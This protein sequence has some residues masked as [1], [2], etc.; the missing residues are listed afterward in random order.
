MTSAE[1]KLRE[2]VAKVLLL[3]ESEVNDDISRKN[4]ESWDSLA[5][6]MLINEIEAAFEVSFTDDDIVEI[7]TVGEL[8]RKLRE[9][10]AAI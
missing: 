7:N 9:L 5:H 4:A 10:R 1:K 8:K 6:L 2:V 3:K